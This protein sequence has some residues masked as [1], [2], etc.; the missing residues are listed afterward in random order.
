MAIS[1]LSRPIKSSCNWNAAGNPIIYKLRRSD[2]TYNQTNN[3][4]GFMQVQIDGI[5]LTAYYQ[6]GNIV[7]VLSS[8]GGAIET[9]GTIT[10]SSFAADTRI[11]L[12]VSYSASTGGII[13]NTSKRTDYKITIDFKDADDDSTLLSGSS[14]SFTH[15]SV[16]VITVD[17]SILKNLLSA[18]W[19]LP[20][21]INEVDAEVSQAFYISYQE[22]YDGAL[23]GSV[24]NDS[25]NVIFAVFA[26]NQIGNANGSNMLEYLPA[27]SDSSWMTKFKLSSVL[28]DLVMWRD[29]PFTLS[30]IWNTGVTEMTAIFTEF[31]VE[32]DFLSGSSE[33]LTE[34]ES[35]INRIKIEVSEED[36]KT[37]RLTLING[38]ADLLQEPSFATSAGWASGGG[39]GPAWAFGGGNTNVQL[40]SGANSISEQLIG[41][42][43]SE[44]VGKKVNYINATVSSGTGNPIGTVRFSFYKDNAQI[45]AYELPYALSATVTSHSLNTPTHLIDDLVGFDEVRCIAFLTSGTQVTIA[46]T[47]F[48]LTEVTQLTSSIDI[49][50]NDAC[51]YNSDYDGLIPEKNPIHLFWK[52]SAGGDS[53][54]NFDKYHEYTFNYSSGKKAK[55]IILFATQLSPVQLNALDELNS[56]GEVYQSPIIDLENTNTINKTAQRV[57]QQVYIISKDGETKTGVIVIPSSDRQLSRDVTHTFSVEIELPEVIGLE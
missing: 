6:V 32:G 27:D 44:V 25:S 23:V 8:S 57:G 17:A 5:D 2:H 3:S 21:T 35:E 37:I 41:T 12:D 39:A 7:Y 45:L 56:I 11:T 49:K 28:S 54:W 36:T 55:R 43:T 51:D 50:V 38:E 29:W 4:A 31:N 15:D 10:A 42:L 33:V 14:L 26:A 52:N 19:T 53:F 13:T 1:I 16:G 46:L 9:F 40:N 47:D 24:T 48:S 20:A 34:N 30:F 18:E 22:F